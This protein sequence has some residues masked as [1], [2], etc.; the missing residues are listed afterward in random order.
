MPPTMNTLGAGE[1]LPICVPPD[2]ARHKGQ[3][4]SILE[5]RRCWRLRREERALRDGGAGT[6]AGEERLRERGQDERPNEEGGG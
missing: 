6:A 1:V 5:R 3:S 2:L 4:A